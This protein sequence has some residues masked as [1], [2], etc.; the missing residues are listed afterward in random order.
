M[1]IG[2][3]FSGLPLYACGLKDDMILFVEYILSNAAIL[4]QG[5]WATFEK[6]YTVAEEY[7]TPMYTIMRDL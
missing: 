5:D 1:F 7:D 6:L 4:R 2:D 3:P